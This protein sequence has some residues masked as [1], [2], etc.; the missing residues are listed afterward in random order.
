MFNELRRWVIANSKHLQFGELTIKFKFH[1]GRLVL[2][3]KSK[4]ERTKPI[5]EQSTLEAIK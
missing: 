1:D 2:I 3:E 5:E 4:S